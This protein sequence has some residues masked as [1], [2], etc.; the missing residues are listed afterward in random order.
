M[1]NFKNLLI[2]RNIMMRFSGVTALKNVS[3]DIREGE[4]HV[5]VGENGAGKSTL[6]KILCG[7]YTPNEGEM[8]LGGKRFNP[9]RPLDAIQ[10][11]IRMVYQE[12]NMLP[13]LS[14]AENIYF[15]KFPSKRGL[16]DYR[17]LYQNT[18][19][20]MKEVGLNGSPQ[21]PVEFLGVAQ[22]VLVQIAKAISTEAKIIILDEPT[23]ALTSK[24]TQRL[25]D[26]VRQ[27]KKKGV[28][29]IYI[30]HRLQEILEIGDRVT[31]LRNGEKVDTQEVKDI[32]IPGIVK[33]MIGRDM[34]TEY[35]FDPDV[36]TGQEVFRVEE[37]KYRGGKNTISLS[38]NRGELLGIAGLV[39]SGRTETMRAIFGADR[40]IQGKIYLRNK[41][42]TI[43]SPKD[44]V[45]HRICLITEDKKM[46]GLILEMPC[47]VNI[48]ITDL[49]QIA[50]LG[51]LNYGKEHKVSKELIK[52]FAIQTPSDLQLVKYL[53]G[54]N[55][56][57]VVIAKWM[58]RKA[59]ILI[60]DEPTC[61]IDVGAKYEIYLLL[62]RIA[63]QG[64]GVIIVSSNLPELIGICHRIIVFSNGK[65]SGEVERDNFN[66]EEI[67]SLAYQNYI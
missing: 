24:E 17:T 41:K 5:L 52:E 31:V 34:E 21:D 56:Q 6:V 50:K 46:Q 26:I 67:L 55:Q 44:A 18:E 57:K 33:M 4:V 19:N 47:S 8:Y 62:W 22:K 25:F 51:L 7:I 28:T 14:I 40:R 43:K 36:K 30:S 66:Q 32:T 59:D 42:I 9:Q 65:V 3:L 27:L 48:T 61:G 23:A 10:A 38:L 58:F 60:F 39:G 11:G 12:F 16:V 15:E 37:L 20:I 64:K 49:T 45:K 13:F 29:V 1:S 53:S 35:P 63:A 54:G 2:F